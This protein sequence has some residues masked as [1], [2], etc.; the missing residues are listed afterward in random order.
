MTFLPVL[1]ASEHGNAD[2]TDRLNALSQ[3]AP[4]ALSRQEHDS[5]TE[6]TLVR[7]RTQA[8]QRSDARGPSAGPRQGARPN[9]QQVVANIRKNSLAHRPGANRGYPSPQLG[10]GGSRPPI[11]PGPGPSGYS[12]PSR[13]Q[14]LSGSQ[15]QPGGYSSPRIP[16]QSLARPPS[17]PQ[18][19]G[20]GQ[21]GRQGRPMRGG[22]ES[23]TSSQQA[24]IRT[25]SP[26]ALSDPPVR[27]Q[28]AKGP[29]TFQD[30]GFQSEK[31]PDKDCVIM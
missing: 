14:P 13:Q 2:A 27:P 22:S 4:A 17:Q 26:T 19:G 23:S 20:P 16:Q 30:M 28:P 7:K 31:L 10:G 9:G 8:K 5:L 24:P 3:S 18:L 11:H 25:S 21:Q 15:P 29:A 12:P 6:N 1:Q